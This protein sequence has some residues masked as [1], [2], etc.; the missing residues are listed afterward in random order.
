VGGRKSIKVD[1]RIVSGDQSRLIADVTSGRFREDL[2]YRLHVFPITVPPLPRAARGHPGVGPAFSGSLF[3][4]RRQ[5]HS[6]RT[7]RLCGFLAAFPWPGNIRQLENTMFRA[8]VLAEGDSLGLAEF[9]QIAAQVPG[10]VGAQLPS[11]PSGQDLLRQDLLQQDLPQ[12]EAGLPPEAGPS[13]ED[14]AGTSVTERLIAAQ[15]SATPRRGW[16]S[17]TKPARCGRLRK[18]NPSLSGMQLRTT[19]DRC[20]RWRGGYALAARR[21]IASLKRWD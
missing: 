16:L 6:L 20:R 10:Q 11:P 19:G 3:R 18:S 5:A 13:E 12:D 2:F 17:L 9:P 4:R 21:F 8:V 7:R 1:V 14:L 15:S